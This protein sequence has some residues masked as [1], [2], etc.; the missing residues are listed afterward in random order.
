MYTMTEAI[1]ILEGRASRYGGD[2]SD[3]IK[4][5]PENMWDSPNELVE[6]WDDKHL[7]HIYPQS[8]YLLM[9]N[10]WDNIVAEDPTLNMQRGAQVMTPGELAAAE[11]DVQL[12]SELIDIIHIDDS[13]ENLEVLMEA[14]V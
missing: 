1:N 12:D 10:D 2:I 3:M 8:D 5:T 4:L 14:V 11:I 9:A 13:I 7:S 6:F